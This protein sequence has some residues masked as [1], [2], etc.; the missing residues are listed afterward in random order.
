MAYKPI[1]YSSQNTGYFGGIKCCIYGGAGAGKTYLLSTAPNPVILNA[2][3][4]VV[5]LKPF[6]LPIID[7]R[8]EEDL[9]GVYGWVAGSEEA[10]QF[11]TI[12]LDSMSDIAEKILDSEKKKNA[13]QR[14]AYGNTQD[15]VLAYTRMFRDLPRFNFVAT[16]KMERLQDESGRLLYFPTVPSTKLAQSIPYMYDLVFPLIKC[17]AEDKSEYRVLQT[18]RDDMYEAKAR[19]NL[20][21][22][23]EPPNLTYIFNKILGKEESI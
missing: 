2:E 6:N 10:K 11:E 23:Y 5:T 9:Y 1:I 17:T 7:I 15:K 4:G 8:S 12:C 21:A 19:T 13:D 16:Y 20:L 22:K 18:Q 14:K 3:S